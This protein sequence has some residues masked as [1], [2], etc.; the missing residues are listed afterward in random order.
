M[1]RED[2]SNGGRPTVVNRREVRRQQR[3]APDHCF[4]GD[5]C[6]GVRNRRIDGISTR[7]HESEQSYG[8]RADF[9]RVVA[10]CVEGWVA[11]QGGGERDLAR[12]SPGSRQEYPCAGGGGGG[13]GGVVVQM[14]GRDL[15]IEIRP[16]TGL[17]K[18]GP[19]ES[20]DDA[21]R[22]GVLIEVPE[23]G[24]GDVE[25]CRV[26]VEFFERMVGEVDEERGGVQVREAG[27]DPGEGFLKI[28]GGQCREVAGADAALED[29]EEFPSGEEFDPAGEGGVLATGAFGEPADDAVRA[30]EERYRLAGLG[31]VPVSDADRVVLDG[32]HASQRIACGG[33]T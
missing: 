13:G 4:I 30:S 3:I 26:R 12:E 17:A 27:A 2:P 33:E 14:G 22:V 5:R 10:R 15:V 28:P 29:G 31:P 32:W 11:A 23:A 18:G 1:V 7:G 6:I 25:Q 21:L 24:D 9:P 20:K 16:I 19:L 8:F